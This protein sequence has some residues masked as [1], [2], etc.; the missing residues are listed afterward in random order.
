MPYIPRSQKQQALDGEIKDAG[1]F[2]FLIHQ[3]IDQY[4]KQKGVSYQTYNDIVGA[5][6]CAKMEL[7]RRKI[8][9]YEKGKILLN[10]DV[11]PYKN[12]D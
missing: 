5:L 7:Y 8:A 1:S 6:D 9:D 3:L 2:N 11:P 10:G 4:L 12:D